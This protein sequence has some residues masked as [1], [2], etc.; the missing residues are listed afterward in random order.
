MIT[1]EDHQAFSEFNQ[2]HI[3][4]TSRNQHQNL[5][6]CQAESVA[7]AQAAHAAADATATRNSSLF[8][9]IFFRNH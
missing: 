2:E 6:I 7:V 5:R 1:Q 9:L 4:I 3:S 8:L